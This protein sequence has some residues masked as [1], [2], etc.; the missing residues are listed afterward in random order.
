MIKN[1]TNEII[2]EEIISLNNKSLRKTVDSLVFVPNMQ[3]RR[4]YQAVAD[5]ENTKSFFVMQSR[6]VDAFNDVSHCTYQTPS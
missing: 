1:K 4:E 5:S 6:M 3:L 2:R